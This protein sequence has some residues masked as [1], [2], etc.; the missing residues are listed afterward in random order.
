MFVCNYYNLYMEN[1]SRVEFV[2]KINII[3]IVVIYT[4]IVLYSNSGFKDVRGEYY[5]I[6]A[7][8]PRHFLI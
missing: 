5:Q 3:I 6:A 2:F 8:P 4:H 7:F 1:G